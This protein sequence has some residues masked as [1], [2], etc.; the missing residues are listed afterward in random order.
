[1]AFEGC[2][3]E[4]ADRA[5]LRLER[6]SG[7]RSCPVYVRARVYEL[8]M[9]R[10]RARMVRARVLCICGYIM[11]KHAYQKQMLNAQSGDYLI[12]GSA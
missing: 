8:H 10:V 2:T 3:G 5:H 6:T 11:E 9:E 12:P 4:R 7:G 1:M